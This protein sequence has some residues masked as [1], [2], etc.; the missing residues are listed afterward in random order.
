MGP[1]RLTL[2]GNV[3]RLPVT[4]AG[5]Q[6]PEIFDKWLLE[7]IYIL[8]RLFWI[9]KISCKKSFFCNLY[10][11]M[12]LYVT[13]THYDLFN[14]RN[15]VKLQDSI[16]I[17]TGKVIINWNHYA[18]MQAT[19][20]IRKQENW[21]NLTHFDKKYDLNCHS[22]KWVHGYHCQLSV[23]TWNIWNFLC[24]RRNFSKILIFS[25][26]SI[27]CRIIRNKYQSEIFI[28]PESINNR[29]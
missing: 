25:N 15:I 1:E 10:V 8:S 24:F 22:N 13:Y 19:I 6:R 3:L 9:D 16:N 26:L 2:L 11:S 17:W 14:V 20:N 23:I 5:L 21:Q 7:S 12:S 28:K 27:C 29:M 4:L 18:S